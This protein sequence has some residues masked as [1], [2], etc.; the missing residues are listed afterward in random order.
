MEGFVFGLAFFVTVSQLPKL[1]G[2]EKGEGDTIRQFF[3]LLG[4]LGNTSGAT[5]ASASPRSCCC[6][7]PSGWRSASPRRADGARA[8]HR[9]QLGARPLG[10]HGVAVVG[11][12]PS[13]LPSVGIPDIAGSRRLALLAAAAGWCS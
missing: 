11:E 7:A 6:S 2:I 3:H 1:F 4:E 12:V 10:E 9:D 8:R 13:G 5:F